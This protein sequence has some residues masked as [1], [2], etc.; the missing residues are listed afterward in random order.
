MHIKV[1][2]TSF[3][4]VAVVLSSALPD[5]GLEIEQR[6]VN[7]TL[8]KR[9]NPKWRGWHHIDC[10]GVEDS[11]NQYC[12][13]FYCFGGNKDWPNLVPV[14]QP[15]GDKFKYLQNSR[16]PLIQYE[17][18]EDK[19]RMNRVYSGCS[20]YTCQKGTSCDEWP[21]AMH[22]QPQNFEPF[23]NTIECVD[24]TENQCE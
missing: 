10:N 2:A 8:I 3:L 21:P 24:G 23:R 6:D 13:S 18:D 16:W 7:A 15:G 22:V 17:S 5:T 20:G 1:F 19:K 12:A 9:R 11:C 4:F 14:D